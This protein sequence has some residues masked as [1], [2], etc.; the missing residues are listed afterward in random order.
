MGAQTISGTLL[1]AATS[2]GAGNPFIF[3]CARSNHTI[4]V[5]A[6]GVPT[7]VKVTL[8]GSLDLVN[9]DTIGTWDMTAGQALGDI[10]SVG[11]ASII[12]VRAHLITLSGG[13]SPAVT[14]NYAGTDN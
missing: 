6:T 12:G 2:T 8:E 1:N 4:Q 9:Y 14:V 11:N 13:T 10:V 3:Q 5:T 7:E